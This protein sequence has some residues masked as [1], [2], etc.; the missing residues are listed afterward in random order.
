MMSKRVATQ[1]ANGRALPIDVMKQIVTKTDGNPLFVEE[2]TKAVLE[3]GILVECRIGYQLDGP[4]T[5]PCHPGN[6]S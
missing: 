3:A 4:V 1:V 6:P 5:A 2:L